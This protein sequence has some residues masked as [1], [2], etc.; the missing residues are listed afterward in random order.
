MLLATDSTGEYSESVLIV[1][2][3]AKGEAE[4]PASPA[5]AASGAS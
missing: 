2:K 5:S 3:P 1:V 4:K